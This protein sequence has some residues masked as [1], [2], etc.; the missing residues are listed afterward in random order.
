M[1][2]YL[3]PV[4]EDDG[5]NIVAWRNDPETLKHCFSKKPITIE[6]NQRF[7]REKVVSGHYK[8]FI[9][10]RIDEAFGVSSYPIAS[11]SLKDFDEEN[12]RCELCV[13]TSSDQEWNSE[14]QSIAVKMM[15]EKAFYEYGMHMCFAIMSMK[16][17]Y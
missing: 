12:H 5:R 11:I 16:S 1:R 8:Q 13:F 6:S 4:T 7:F 3:R 17:I 14:S 2:I 10:E 9:V 15:L